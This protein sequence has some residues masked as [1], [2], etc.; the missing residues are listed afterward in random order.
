M[1]FPAK[2]F[3]NIGRNAVP[4]ATIFFVGGPR[5]SEIININK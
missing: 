4:G 1:S 5:V 2:S 3:D